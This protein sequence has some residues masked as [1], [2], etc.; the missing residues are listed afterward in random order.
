MSIV[1]GVM[2]RKTKDRIYATAEHLTLK[3]N[4]NVIV[5]T[6]HGIEFGII[7]ENEKYIEEK[8]FQANKILR[9]MTGD[10][11]IRLIKNK[12]KILKIQKIV[13]Q[14][15][16]EHG[17]GMKL[18]CVQHTFDC[19]KLFVYYTSETRID[20][21]G[22]IK[23]LGRILKTRIQM[24]QIGV[25]DESKMLGGLGTCGQVLCCQKF[26]KDFNSITI[27]MTK[28]QDLS[29]NTAKLSGL[30]GRLKCCI[31]YENDTYKDA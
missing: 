18:T 27:D 2:L 22:L 26:L 16:S 12:M 3:L 9:K 1:I 20:F 23:D 24:V 14:K 6:E 30:C 7:C 21:R 4:D 8:G 13:E 15:A 19:S 28:E 31:F 17:L 25:R 5:E 29:L 11:K 10:D